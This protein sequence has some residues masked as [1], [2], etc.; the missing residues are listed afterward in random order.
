[1]TQNCMSCRRSMTFLGAIAGLTIS[2]WAYGADAGEQKQPEL[3]VSTQLSLVS[4]YVWRGLSQTWGKPASQITV[5]AAHERGAYASFFASNVAAQFV[6]NA[7][8]EI[9]LEAGYKS[10][11]GPVEASLGGLLVMYPGSNFDN[12]SFTPAFE[13]SDP[14]TVELYLGATWAGFNARLG[15]IPTKFYGWNTNNSGVNGVFN[16][17]QPHA[18]LTGDSRGALNAELAY[19]HPFNG[20]FSVQVAIGRQR[21][22]NSTG[23][24][25]N[26][27]R[28]ALFANLNGGWSLGLAASATSDPDGFKDYGSLTNNGQRSTPSKATVAFSVSRQL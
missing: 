26:Y 12:A 20:R 8:V 16:S 23:L 13:S 3:S 15:Y 18:G 28:M 19:L 1:M 11:V 25:W 17:E 21:I 24:S 2:C 5:S 10:K 14:T 6:P 4:D 7:S 9:D 27:G 22:P